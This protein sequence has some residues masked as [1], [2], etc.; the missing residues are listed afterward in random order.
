MIIKLCHQS[1]ITPI[2]LVR[3]EEQVKIL[4]ELKCQ[5][6]IN[7]SAPDYKQKMAQT[8]AK[9]KPSTCLECIGGTTTGEMLNYLGFKSTLILYGVLSEQ[10]AG[11]IKVI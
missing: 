5:Y 9:V 2:A 1:N 6:I 11:D 7:S 4:E 10:P 3:R 8:C